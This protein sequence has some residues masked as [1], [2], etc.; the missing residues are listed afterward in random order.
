MDGATAYGKQRSD[1][2]TAGQH[3]SN[4]FHTARDEMVRYF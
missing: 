4:M 3:A 2:N 1:F